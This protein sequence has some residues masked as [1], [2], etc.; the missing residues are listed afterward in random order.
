MI[1]LTGIKSAAQ[2]ASYYEADD[3]YSEA[4]EAPSRWLG[5]GAEALALRGPVDRAD[6]QEMLNGRLP[7]GQELGRVHQGERQ[8]APGWDMTFSAAKSVSVA[9]FVGGDMRLQE[10]HRE[11]VA[12][13]VGY[14]Q[15]HAQTRIRGEGGTIER[16]DTNS[17]LVAAFDHATSRHLDPQMHSHC[18]ILNATQDREGRFRS[19]EG[20][21]FYRL[22]NSANEV[23]SQALA[24][25]VRALGYEIEQSK[26]GWELSGVSR[27]MRD[28]YSGRTAAINAWLEAHGYDRETASAAVRER[29]S[30]ATRPSKEKGVEHDK[31]R[32]QWRER[33]EA[34]GFDLARTTRTGKAAEAEERKEAASHAVKRAA[35][36]LAERS[37]RF[38]GRDLEQQALREARASGADLDAIRAEI[39]DAGERGELVT[40][41][42]STAEGERA[43][44]TTEKAIRTE[45]A[46][47]GV[48]RAGRE[49]VR[50]VLDI[51]A[52][53]DAV[54]EAQEGSAYP[55]TAG[56]KEAAQGILASRNRIQAVQ[57]YAGTAKTTTVLK[58]VAAQAAAQGYKVRG[59]APTRSAADQLAEGAGLADAST[60]KAALL[61][62]YRRDTSEASEPEM[63]LVDESSMM[64]AKDAAA[65]LRA[66][67]K[68]DARVVL[69]GDVAQL[70]SVEAGESFRQLQAAGMQTH[71]LDDIVRQSNK[72]ALTAVYQSLD[73]DARAAMQSIERS[74]QII[75]EKDA[76]ARRDRIAADYLALDQGERKETLVID[77]T[78]AGRA[79]LNTK[80]RDGL[81]AEGTLSGPEIAATA[82][83]KKDLSAAEA[84]DASRYEAGDL[85]RFGAS[86]KGPGI[87]A[88][89]FY[90]VEEI[91]YSKKTVVLMPESGGSPVRW[92]P[93]RGGSKT[94]EA[95]KEDQ[96]KVAVG[97]RLQWTKNGSQPGLSNGQRLTVEGV[98]NHVVT[99]RDTAGR[100]HEIDT[101]KREGQHFR[102]AYAST[103]NAAQGQT[104][105]RVLANLSTEQRGLLSQRSY[106]TTI[107]RAKEDIRL[108]SDDKQAVA[109]QIE[110]NSG[111]R[112]T[113]LEDIKKN[114]KQREARQERAGHGPDRPRDQAPAKEK[115]KEQERGRGMEM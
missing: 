31:L 63:W 37:S 56:Q 77:P 65:L 52:A 21:E 113:A 87:K 1:N 14:V 24:A 23:Y 27:Q 96:A 61:G 112:Q 115:A 84:K 5:A 13:A 68:A 29:A 92:Q 4:G 22:Q 69:V 54:R 50:P 107:S 48:E 104:S 36:H 101:S 47:L 109:R 83:D 9:A 75:E 46:M 70:G 20:R 106:Y 108:Y 90:R 10:A 100:R 80:I 39:K 114:E 103:V 40:R 85:V 34:N 99:V 51:G 82:L 32:D 81:R 93:G 53:G 74:G 55:W 38:T 30:L 88:G 26:D 110:R 45:N 58:T 49:A 111:Q 28:L 41:M 16:Q 42:V 97:E 76:S 89:E 62:E 2:A 15:E 6:F 33:A 78:R 60:V 25:K 43:G 59:L 86:V 79:E 12:E 72:D 95:Y 17:L 19:L 73:G 11:A 94:V 98:A 35:E 71:V 67:E 7:N 8:H 44:W 57:G 66:A 64:S 3:Y 18:V 102:H 91:D 105:Q